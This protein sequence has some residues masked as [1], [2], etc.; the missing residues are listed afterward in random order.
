[1]GVGAGGLSNATIM[2]LMLNIDRI[3]QIAHDFPSCDAVAVDLV[4]MQS[5]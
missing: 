3:M 1:M 2:Y 5:T 4:P